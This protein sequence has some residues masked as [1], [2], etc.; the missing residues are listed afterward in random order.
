MGGFVLE[1]K[2]Y[3]PYDYDPPETVPVCKN[4]VLGTPRKQNIGTVGVIGH[5]KNPLPKHI[6]E[7]EYNAVFYGEDKPVKLN[8]EHLSDLEER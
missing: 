8:I 6:F 5:G 4:C 7:M 2:P 1:N 3:D